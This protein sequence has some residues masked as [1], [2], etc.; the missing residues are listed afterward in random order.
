M[1]FKVVV[2]KRPM[3]SKIFDV[4]ASCSIM[5]AYRPIC[6]YLDLQWDEICMIFDFQIAQS[7][8][9]MRDWESLCTK[10]E[11]FQSF[12]IPKIC[13]VQPNHENLKQLHYWILKLK[14]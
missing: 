9:A 6:T 2:G 12:F 5:D 13:F 7:M 10:L 11:E 4:I 8:R 14:Y 3:Q 1:L